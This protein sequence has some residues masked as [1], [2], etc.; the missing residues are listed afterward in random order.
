MRPDGNSGRPARALDLS[1]IT[2]RGWL[3]TGAS[4]LWR[5]AGILC[6]P[7][8][9]SCAACRA[10]RPSRRCWRRGCIFFGAARCLARLTLVSSE[11]GFGFRFPLQPGGSCSVNSWTRL[12]T[13]RAGEQVVRMT[14]ETQQARWRLAGRPALPKPATRHPHHQNW[15]GSPRRCSQVANTHAEPLVAAEYRQPGTGDALRSMAESP[16][17]TASPSAVQQ[18]RCSH[19]A[20]R[21]YKE[22]TQLVC[23]A[24]GGG[25]GPGER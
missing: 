10:A 14:S 19:P 4:R 22:C 8:T 21:V 15:P 18:V 20:R 13:P 6:V 5:G 11:V 3:L 12:N 23:E 16:K 25:Q 9:R 7:I 17:T 2:A 24:L 1:G